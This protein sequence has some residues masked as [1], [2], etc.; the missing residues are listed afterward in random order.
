MRRPEAT[1][2][3]TTRNRQAEL[4]RAVRSTLRQTANI[5]VLVV[6]DASTDGTPAMLARDFPE[7]SVYRSDVVSGC[8]VQRNA[9]ARL[10][11]S[12]V[13][14]SLDDDALFSSETTVEHALSELQHPRV[15][16]VAIPLV[17]ERRSPTVRPRSPVRATDS[18]R[19]YVVPTFMGG[20]H[21]LRR[22]I[23]LQLG[24]YRGVLFRQG[25]EPDYCL[26]ML[27]AGYVVRLG[28]ADPI[29]HYESPTR[30]RRRMDIYG[31][32]N[33][34]LFCWHNEPMPYCVLRMAELS[35]K[36]LAL[37]VRIGRPV[38][39]VWGLALG[40]AACWNERGNRAPV[41]REVSG[42]YRLLRRRGSMSLLELE[43]RL[44]PLSGVSTEPTAP[45]AAFELGSL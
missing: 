10:A 4:R 26:R 5:E 31:S 24:G 22:D 35:L 1:V 30:D 17:D 11:R 45:R 2:V 13:I 16:A 36:G 37:G 27:A 43:P 14:I 42:L 38:H 6:D 44:P 28:R 23:F 39:K 18:Q 29:H 34:I 40:Y 3:I 8:I 7:V 9:A 33:T 20:A 21:A 32:R 25:E 41:S 19:V 15:G 12:N